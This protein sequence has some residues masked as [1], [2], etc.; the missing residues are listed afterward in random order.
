M[1]GRS[2]GVLEDDLLLKAL[3]HDLG[4]PIV[5]RDCKELVVWLVVG[6]WAA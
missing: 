2:P 6:S 4:G 1:V 5:L 3:D